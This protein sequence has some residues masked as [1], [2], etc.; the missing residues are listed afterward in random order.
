MADTAAP[1]VA[2]AAAA[3]P[4]RHRL[5][6]GHR[7]AGP[8]CSPLFQVT[9]RCLPPLGCSCRFV[10]SAAVWDAAIARTHD[11]A[12]VAS[13]V[14]YCAFIGPAAYARAAVAWAAT[15]WDVPAPTTVSACR[16]ATALS[17]SASA[18]TSHAG[19]GS[20]SRLKIHGVVRAKKMRRPYVGSHSSPSST[21]T[22][23]YLVSRVAAQK[24]ECIAWRSRGRSFP[25]ASLLG[26][27][28]SGCASPR[29]RR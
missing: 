29:P 16:C 2:A 15:P 12:R 5:R 23:M 7:A 1:A 24:S 14:A 20:G 11:R 3:A 22:L 28:S 8:S 26:H 17:S 18:S 13:N 21:C 6:Y 19:R 27:W 25:H 9:P 4:R 10:T